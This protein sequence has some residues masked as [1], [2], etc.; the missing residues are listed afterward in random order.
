MNAGLYILINVAVAGFVGGITNHY[1]IKMLFHP[2]TE[3][4][5]GGWRVPFTPGLIPKRKDEIGR[6]LGKVVAD[7]L[8]T[9][10]GLVALLGKPEFRETIEG[11]L[12]GFVHDWTSREESVRELLLRVWPEE[13]LDEV[14]EKLFQWSD[15]KIA[16][17][18]RWLWTK[19]GWADRRIG[20]LMPNWSGERREEWVHRATGMLADE[21]RKELNSLQ[22]ERMLRQM[23]TR[24][25]GQAGGFLGAMAGLFLDEDKIAGKV[26]DAL[27]QQLESPAMLGFVSNFIRERLKRLEAVTLDEAFRLASKGREPADW[28]AEQ[29]AKLADVRG[30]FEGLLGMKLADALGGR[31]EWLLER[32]PGS[33]ER[34]LALLSASMDRLVAAVR[35]PVLVEEEVRKFPVEQL[36]AILLSVSGKEFRAI[37]WLGVLLGGIIGLFQSLLLLW[38]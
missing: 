21:I 37:T 7:H 24:F 36:E 35:L 23:T 29:A 17:G 28:L 16:E 20:E 12:L 33:A 1:A 32:V 5:I 2:R 3:K 18:I 27:I 22:G 11:R 34:L 19:E 30:R 14:L 10:E 38:R 6:S 13:R 9:T 15:D 4:R 25:M 31:R 26:K 8:V